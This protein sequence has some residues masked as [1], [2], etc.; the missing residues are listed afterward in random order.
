MMLAEDGVHR[1]TAHTM[2][3][4]PFIISGA[5][6]KLKPGRLADIAPTIMDLIGLERPEAMTGESLLN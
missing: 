1:H 6:V 4:A 5:D 2:N 3:P